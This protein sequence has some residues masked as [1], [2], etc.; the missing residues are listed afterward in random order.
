MSLCSI[1]VFKFREDN[2]RLLTMQTAGLPQ[3]WLNLTNWE[4][5]CK[6]GSDVD[7]NS[8]LSHSGHS[9]SAGNEQVLLMTFW[10]WQ[11]FVTSVFETIVCCEK[12]LLAINYW[13]KLHATVCKIQVAYICF[14]TLVK[15]SI[16]NSLNEIGPPEKKVIILNYKEHTFSII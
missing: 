10:P 14:F 16:H 15:C 3:N 4:M 13:D 7:E 8:E 11:K 2:K 5:N 1:A 9:F 12:H 6:G